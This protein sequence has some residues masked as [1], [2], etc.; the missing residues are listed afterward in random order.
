MRRSLFRLS[1][2]VLAAC[3]SS[4]SSSAPHDAP[5]SDD[6]S[7]SSSDPNHD[8]GSGS[9]RSHFVGTWKVTEGSSLV[10]CPGVP[11]WP[12]EG[13]PLDDKESVVH[14]EEGATPGTITVH[15][16]GAGCSFTYAVTGNV[17]SLS[18]PQT[19]SPQGPQIGG[20]SSDGGAGPSDG[21]TGGHRHDGG[22]PSTWLLTHD[23]LTLAGDGVTF[24]EAYEEDLH[25]YAALCD[26]D[27]I[28]T[29]DCHASGHD[30]LTK[31]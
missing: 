25:D 6:A 18:A 9:D 2:T 3:S 4:H 7:A 14:I 23:T 15:Q 17:A 20:C 26:G 8:A 21:G 22:V 16:E 28:V 13:M 1:F 10:T 30:T 29:Y 12:A 19:C 31:Q 11:N 24:A 5:T 27:T